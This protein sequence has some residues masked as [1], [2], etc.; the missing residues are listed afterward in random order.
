M[1]KKVM[2]ISIFVFLTVIGLLAGSI[3]PRLS[4]HPEFVV[5]AFA[6]D[7]HDHTDEETRYTCSMHPFVIQDEPGTCPICGM[8]LV[9]M[10]PTG[11]QAGK[12]AAAERKIKYWAAPMDPTYIRDEPGKSPMGMDLVPV[13]EDEVAEGAIV[14]VDPVTIQNMGIR[15]AIATRRDI[16]KTISTVGLVGYDET[17][18]YSVNSKISGWVEKLYVSKTGQKVKKGAPLLE[19]YSP[20]LVTAQEEYLLALSGYENTG[21]SSQSTLADSSKRLL[22]A[23]KRRLQLWDISDR[24]IRRLEKTRQTRK[25][26]TLY[27]PYGGIVVMKM[28]NEGQFIKSGM[29]LF[30]IADL[31]TVWVYADIYENELPWV[32]EGLDAEILLP[33]AGSEK[34]AATISYI[35]P[36]VEPKTRTI[37][38]RLDLKNKD[39]DLRP[40][41]FVTVQIKTNPVKQVLVVP[42]EAVLYS[43]E[44]NTVF[45]ALDGGKFEP[46]RVKI[47]LRDDQGFI[48]I[49]QGLLEGEKVVTSAQF[50]LDSESK[51][52]EAIQKMINPARVVPEQQN[53]SEDL[54]GDE[55][56]EKKE[57]EIDD[58]F[59]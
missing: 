8:D 10:K 28:A 11:K 5:E 51:L 1:T 19:I 14:T 50:M 57:I 24:D 53:S 40:D 44:K 48:Q 16:Q 56:P 13:Y 26:M 17:G 22:D 27:A 4:G 59:Q 41:M 33:Y 29:E 7:G 32:R 20:E 46:R 54:F 55:P 12:A 23:A 42:A 21:G 2:I 45:V 52:Q 34:I 37:K 3:I 31:S 25:T 47:G 18:Q 39:L 30:Q 15:T 43:G 36:Y 9:K 35:Y 38:A 6:A 49:V 58:L